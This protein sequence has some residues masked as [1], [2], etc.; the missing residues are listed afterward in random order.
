VLYAQQ[1]QQTASVSDVHYLR[2]RNMKM[3]IDSN[4]NVVA[5]NYV[6]P[7]Q[8]AVHSCQR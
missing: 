2:V 4:I 5:F 8:P 7:K 6:E 1:Q 3:N